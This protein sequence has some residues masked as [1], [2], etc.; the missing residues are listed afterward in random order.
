MMNDLYEV[1]ITGMNENQLYRVYKGTPS[2]AEP[3]TLAGVVETVDRMC[4][5]A[6]NT[7]IT[8]EVNPTT[9]E[10]SKLRLHYF[11]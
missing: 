10:T 4:P 2:L 1:N 11:L 9:V 5:L 7:E 6:A 8:L 3:Q